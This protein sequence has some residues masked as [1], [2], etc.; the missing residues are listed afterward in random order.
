M[1]SELN[2]MINIL[3]D[4]KKFNLETPMAHIV[5]RDPDFIMFGDACLE[6]GGGFSEN[7]S[8]GMLNGLKNQSFIFK[9]PK[10][11]KKMSYLK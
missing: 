2:T 4:P 9:E 7:C 6:T 8:G 1:K 11:I 10:G 3:S 5:K